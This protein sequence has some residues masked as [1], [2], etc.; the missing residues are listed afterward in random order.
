MAKAVVNVM[1][2]FSPFLSPALFGFPPALFGLD[3]VER[4]VSL[5]LVDLSL[6]LDLPAKPMRCLTN[7]YRIL[8]ADPQNC[9]SSLQSPFQPL[10][11]CGKI[12]ITLFADAPGPYWFKNCSALPPEPWKTI[13]ILHLGTPA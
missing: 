7:V 3:D 2:E 5:G 13:W 11:A 12:K 10:S 4:A 9:L 8:F 6:S 1:A